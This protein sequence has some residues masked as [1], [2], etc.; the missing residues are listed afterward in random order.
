M[1]MMIMTWLV[2]VAITPVWFMGLPRCLGFADAES[3]CHRFPLIPLNKPNGKSKNPL[4]ANPLSYV[5]L[6]IEDHLRNR[7]DCEA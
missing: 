6:Y 2:I 3:V 7:S 1:M 5:G 4:L